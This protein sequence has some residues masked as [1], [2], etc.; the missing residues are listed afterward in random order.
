MEYAI[1]IPARFAS[2]RLPGK[3]LV[4]IKGIPML[5]RTYNQCKKV[6]EKINIYVATDSLKIKNECT[7]N[8][9]P[10]IMTSKKC[11]TGTDRVAEA[12][13]KI[14]ENYIVNVQGDEPLIN[15]EDISA[16]IREHK[17]NKKLVVNGYAE[18]RN[19]NLYKNIHIPKVVFDK[20]SML[21]YMSR[22][23]I[24]ANKKRE[25]KNAFR[26]ICIYCY[27]KKELS[28]FTRHK[29]KSPLEKIE[30]IEILRF[31]EIGSKVKML[32]LSDRSISVDIKA[33]VK[34]VEKQL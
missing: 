23:P 17:K 15:P 27:S 12:S 26:Q 33:D 25:M 20:K 9:I 21:L 2:K 5:I 7:K 16:V 19:I 11:L 4:L 3:P 10:V 8:K 32:R 18:I 1:I 24:P 14:R 22:S 34:K 29:V 13:N 30:D 31:L 6:K 28:K